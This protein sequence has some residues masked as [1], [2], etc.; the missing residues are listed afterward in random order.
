[1]KVA[2]SILDCK[3]RVEGVLDLN[4]TSISYIHIDVMDGKFVPSI[5]FGNIEEIKNIDKVSKYPL[6]VHLM[7]DNPSD[8]IKELNNM[9]IDFITIHLEVDKDIKKIISEIRALGYKVGLSIKPNTPVISIKE[10]LD[11]IDLVLLMSV[12]P[13][14]GGQKFMA[15]TVDRIKELNTL[16]NNRNILVEVDGGI[17][18]ETITKLDNVDIVV[19]GSYITKSDNYSERVLEL[20]EY[21]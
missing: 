6:D 19:V 17:N 2:A 5:Q 21:K 20:L 4:K 16:I 12:E 11:D 13:G 15:S 1:M 8:Y 7:V 9:N 3:D 10:Y 14:L 18:N